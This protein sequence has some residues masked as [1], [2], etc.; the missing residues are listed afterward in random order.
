MV[1]RYDNPAQAEFIN[2]YVPIPFEEL[3]TLGRAAGERLNNT[4]TQYA[5]A[6]KLW[7][8]FQSQ[9]A[10]DM[11]RWDDLTMGRVRP[12]IDA[13]AANPDLMKDAAWQMQIQS[14]IANTDT[15]ALGRLKQG[16]AN[17]DAYQ[18]AVRKLMASGQFNSNWHY[19]NFS[20]WDTLGA[21]GLFNE[22][23]TPYMS[24]NDLV[25]PY[26]DNLKPNYIGSKGGYLW[27]GV[28]ADRTRSQVNAHQSDILA[29]PQAQ[30]HIQSYI[31]AGATPEQARNLFLQQV[32]T[33][34]QEAAWEGISGVDQYGLLAARMRAAQAAEGGA[35][36]SR[37]RA[38]TANL[39]IL[40]IA[41]TAAATGQ[42][43]DPTNMTNEQM[44]AVSQ[45][46]DNAWRNAFSSGDQQA[47]RNLMNYATINLGDE[48]K[49]MVDPMYDPKYAQNITIGSGA[50]R[51]AQ[52]IDGNSMWGSV[53]YN[54]SGIPVSE[55]SKAFLL[56]NDRD[57]LN[58][59]SGSSTVKARKIQD[60]RDNY[61][62]IISDFVNNVSPLFLTNGNLTEYDRID[63]NYPFAKSQLVGGTAYISEDQLDEVLEAMSGRYGDLS[64]GEI[65][66]IL[67][68]GIGKNKNHA[69]LTEVEDFKLGDKDEEE[70]TYYSFTMGLPFDNPSKREA[71]DNRWS[72]DTFGGSSSYKSQ[73]THTKY[74]WDIH[75]NMGD[76]TNGSNM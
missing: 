40:K 68:K 38:N 44:A 15:A 20:N 58:S 27:E 54:K 71:F 8:D 59:V 17:F 18:D 21:N 4:L 76:G 36:Q 51:K 37:N 6:R 10:V 12:Y 63:E 60:L 64:K 29:T 14:A 75:L 47:I 66:A 2:T 35:E 67:T 26:V 11:Q 45:A 25:H 69:I 55:V 13:A 56:N 42:I 9:S 1:N 7:S 5:N 43:V 72:A 33:A 3:Y 34:A 30:M 62:N 57:L 24:V 70:S 39:G 28:T 61:G 19:K 23:P 74:G 16:A 31:N 50:T 32:D 65:K 49:Y 53:V 41:N 73:G 52:R 48:T 46:Y 22:T